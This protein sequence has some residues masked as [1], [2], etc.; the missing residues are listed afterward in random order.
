MI[1]LFGC[2]I[3][4][5][6]I[7]GMYIIRSECKESSPLP[8]LPTPIMYS[9]DLTTVTSGRLSPNNIVY[10]T[11]HLTQLSRVWR[12]HASQRTGVKSARQ[13]QQLEYDSALIDR[14][15]H[16]PEIRR[17]KR[18]RHVP[19]AVKKAGEIKAEEL[20][21]IKRRQENERKHSKKGSVK[22]RNERE[23]VVLAT[24]Q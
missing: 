2:G 4:P 10:W 5:V 20:K 24:E 17:I 21:A 19:K 16:M 7:L 9:L 18:H 23:K 1:G 22:R 13:R 14:Y 15:G 8:G 11:I 12:A 6:G 3:E